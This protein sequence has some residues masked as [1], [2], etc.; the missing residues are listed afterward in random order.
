MTAFVDPRSDPSPSNG[1]PP[2]RL[3]ADP[4]DLKALHQLCR[5][6]RVYEVERW[7]AEG[8]PLQLAQG[9]ASKRRAPSALEIALEKGQHALVLLLLC[10]GYDPNLEEYSPLDLALQSRSWDLLDLLLAWG[11]DPRQADLADLFGTY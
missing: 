8:R 3:A 9:A 6:A 1:K 7:I 10:N 11:A 4:S 2:P 5:Q